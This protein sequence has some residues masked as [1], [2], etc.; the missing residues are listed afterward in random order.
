VGGLVSMDG[1]TDGSHFWGRDIGNG[2]FNGMV[3]DLQ[4]I[5]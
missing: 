1:P 2:T 5:L 4:V 3:G